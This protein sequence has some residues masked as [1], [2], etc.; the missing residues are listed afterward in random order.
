V[1]E[2]GFGA[3]SLGNLYR[4]IEDDAARA[5]IDAAWTAGI[6]YFDTAPYYGFGLSESRLGAALQPMNRDGFV[7]STKV[8]RLLEPAP[9]VTDASERHG[10][11]SA[12]P[13]EPVYD[14][15]Y[16]GVMRSFEDSLERLGL[17]RI[18]V[19]L[20]HD[21][22]AMTHGSEHRALFKICMDGGYKALEELRSKGLVRAL[23]LGVNECDACEAAMEFGRFDCFL[24]AGRYTLLEQGALASLLP[25]CEWHGATLIVGGAYNSGILATGTRRGGV[26]RYNYEPASDSVIER[27]RRIEAVCETYGVTLA[28]AALQFPLAHRSVSSVIPGLAS[29]DQVQ[30]TMGLY[31]ETI[32]GAFWRELKTQ[33]LIRV[34][35]PTP[36]S[37]EAN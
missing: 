6:R 29:A 28:A 36:S 33:G 14:Y 27:V 2:L 9:Q 30:E 16:R 8:G 18:D 7:L 5:T 3:A 20:I 26:L 25:K 21:I 4:P 15:S 32:S 35:A 22:G 37:E 10:F 11:C 34:D 31:R 1:T 17:A 23:G 19:L 24:L 13:F 12:L